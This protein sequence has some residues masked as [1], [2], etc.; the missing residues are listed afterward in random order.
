MMKDPYLLRAKLQRQSPEYKKYQKSYKVKNRDKLNQYYL[1]RLKN[2]KHKMLHN[3]RNSI[4]NCVKGKK[5]NR[6]IKYI[7][8]S[9]EEFVNH[10]ESQFSG[11]MKWENH[12]KLWHLDHKIPVNAFTFDTEDDLFVCFNYKNYHPL[13]CE[14]NLRKNDTIVE[15][16]VSA[17]N[18]KKDLTLYK[19]WRNSLDEDKLGKH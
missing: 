3:I 17:R 5:K 14:E 16:G 1:D 9:I 13:L 11:N 4:R 15:I 18:L 10:I 7:G 12:G 19:K 2:P 6:T 8:C